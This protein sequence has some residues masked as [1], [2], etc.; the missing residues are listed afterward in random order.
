LPARFKP[1]RVSEKA[2]L[3]GVAASLLTASL[4]VAAA[5][6]TGLL[7]EEVV[8]VEH[9][10]PKLEVW[11]DYKVCYES[12]VTGKRDLN[13]SLVTYY[14]ERAGSGEV[15]VPLESRGCI[16][17]PA[18]VSNFTVPRLLVEVNGARYSFPYRE[19][20]TTEP[21]MLVARY[22]VE[23]LGLEAT[24]NYRLVVEELRVAA[25]WSSS[26][27][28]VV[29]ELRGYNVVK[30]HFRDCGG[31]CS[32]DVKPE[33]EVTAYNVRIVAERIPRIQA[34]VVAILAAIAGLAALTLA[35]KR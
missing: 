21:G 24:I 11:V 17:I 4:L 12:Y 3:L 13:V 14:F 31:S 10:W 16:D 32:L 7:V 23:G 9:G 8:L 6:I 2:L 1:G 27:K 5:T 34:L 30:T 15:R 18:G 33:D 25:S 29:E 22:A 19:L 28:L 35:F 26:Y 20:E